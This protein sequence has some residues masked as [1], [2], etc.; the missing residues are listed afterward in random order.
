MMKIRVFFVALIIGLHAPQIEAQVAKAKPAVQPSPAAT[1]TGPRFS[2]TNPGTMNELLAIVEKDR[3]ESEKAQAG[4]SGKPVVH[5]TTV[6][7][8]Y[9]IKTVHLGESRPIS[10]EAKGIVELWFAVPGRRADAV[11]NYLN[12]YRI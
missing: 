9:F 5:I 7:E 11:P 10:N 6:N 12:E 1:A 8:K 3:K 4:Q 2:V